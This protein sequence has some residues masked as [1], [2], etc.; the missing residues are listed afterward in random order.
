[1]TP[2]IRRILD[3]HL[4]RR[5]APKVRERARNLRK[6]M[7]PGWG[8]KQLRAEYVLILGARQVAGG[9]QHYFLGQLLEDLHQHL[10]ALMRQEAA[11]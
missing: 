5:L 2:A 8:E 4:T 9:A 1:M 10:N 3:A 6:A 11:A 7:Y